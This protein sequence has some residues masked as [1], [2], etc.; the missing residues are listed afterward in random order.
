MGD[1]PILGISLYPL[2]ISRTNDRKD[3][4]CEA[5]ITPGPF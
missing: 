3:G 5:L 1:I 4:M 2:R